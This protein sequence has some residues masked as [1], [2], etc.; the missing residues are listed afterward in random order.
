MAGLASSPDMTTT[1]ISGACRPGSRTASD[2][3]SAKAAAVLASAAARHNP[4][5]VQRLR[6]PD[7]S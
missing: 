7:P 6:R 2:T 3:A 5:L 1:I 4:R